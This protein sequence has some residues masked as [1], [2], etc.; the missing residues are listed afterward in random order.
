MSGP[1]D[2][3][4]SGY[5]SLYAGFDSPLQRQL[6]REAYGEDI[7]QHSWVRSEELRRDAGRLALSARSR[8]LDLGCGPCGPLTFLLGAAG[9]R[10]TGVDASAAA[11]A[12]GRARAASLGLESR[13][14][15]RQTDLDEP[16]PFA[17]ASF[18]AA[19][20]LDAVIHLKDRARLFR[21]VPRG[22]VPGDRRRG[23]HRPRLR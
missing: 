8:L 14:T 1:P 9:C 10:G 7:G 21:D 17:E 3:G 15:V 13:M 22:P 6:R 18:D 20:C 19:I 16:L 4:A 23:P 12:A 11:L 5:E 2:W